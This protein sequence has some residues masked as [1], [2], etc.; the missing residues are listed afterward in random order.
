MVS[1]VFASTTS[2]GIWNSLVAHYTAL[3][4]NVPMRVQFDSDKDAGNREKHGV[5]MTFGAEVI[6]DTNRLDILDVRFATPW[7]GV[8]PLCKEWP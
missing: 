6:A 7:R 4:C 2:P 8:Q 3:P 5:P 1:I